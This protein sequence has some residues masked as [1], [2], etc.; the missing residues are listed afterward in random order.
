MN[1]NEMCSVP[2]PGLVKGPSM[3]KKGDESQRDVFG[4][5]SGSRER[6]FYEEKG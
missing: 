4:S 1:R 6:T 5:V 3:R 2:F